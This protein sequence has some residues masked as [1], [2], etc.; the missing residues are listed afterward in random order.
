M[1]QIKKLR[2]IIA[3]EPV[4]NHGQAALCTLDCGHT[5]TIKINRNKHI[6]TGQT[7]AVCVACLELDLADKDYDHESDR[8]S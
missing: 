6:V 2:K 3:F 7:K 8:S 4:Y 5:I 1:K